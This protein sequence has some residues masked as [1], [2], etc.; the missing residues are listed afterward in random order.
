MVELIR[1]NKD[2]SPFTDQAY[3]VYIKAYDQTGEDKAID[4]S[5]SSK[6]SS[7]G[8]KLLF[9]FFDFVRFASLHDNYSSN[10]D[11]EFGNISN[12]LFKNFNLDNLSENGSL[13]GTIRGYIEELKKYYFFLPERLTDLIE[14]KKLKENLVPNKSGMSYEGDL[15]SVVECIREILKSLRDEKIK[16]WKN[17]FEKYK[18]DKEG[19]DLEFRT[20]QTRHRRDLDRFSKIDIKEYIDKLGSIGDKKENNGD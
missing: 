2:P 6:T 5:P 14:N 8:Y 10:L 7:L 4:W 19:Y 12:T 18:E 16:F 20:K 3:E 1:Q 15:D 17:V 9:A 11:N 13:E